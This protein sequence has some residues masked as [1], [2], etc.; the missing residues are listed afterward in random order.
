MRKGK[1]LASVLLAGVM[2]VSVCGCGSSGTTTTATTA[3]KAAVTNA[4]TKAAATTQGKSATTAAAKAS[5]TSGAAAAA[6]KGGTVKVWISSGAEDDVYRSMFKDIES[7]LSVTID[8]QYYSKDELD[9][10]MQASGI[11][12][13]MPDI[14]VADY[15]LLPNY[16][17]AGYL[18]P[19]DSYVK[20]D[21]KSD[22]LSSI[23]DESTVDGKMM[24]VA[25]FDGGMAMWGNKEMLDKAGVKYP[26]SY[27]DAWTKEQFEDALA[28]L[29]ESG[30]KYPLYIR[31][32]NPSTLYYTYFPIVHSF[33]GDYMDRKTKLTKDALNSTETKAAFSYISE[34]V[35]KGYVDATCNYD[36][37][38]N[39]KK[40]NALALIGHWKYTDYKKGLGDDNLVLIPI[41]NFGKGVYTCSGSVVWAM[42]TSAS[43]HGVAD[44]AWSVMNEVVSSEN[45]TKVVKVNGAIPA[46]KSVMDKIPE[47]QKGGKLYL[48]REQLEGGISYLRPYTPAHMT[49]YTELK[50]LY[51][52]VIGGAD[53]SKLLDKAVENIDG[54]I[55]ENNWNK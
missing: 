47:Y 53:A 15:L 27:K 34:L 49:I 44:Q 30:V 42:T 37:S 26:T 36:D 51:G 17:E 11:A 52:D 32:N 12:G 55:K 33:G 35:K 50:N 2:A 16:C 4:V 24:S 13:D 8:A 38:F 1:V 31:Q 29:K 40:E 28:K 10:K 43:K 25:Q 5:A 41:P 20:S 3:A 22:F 14:L 6:K 19:L 48:Y 39:V 45:I 18:A 46:R 23:V 9:S 7:K 54:V 21:L